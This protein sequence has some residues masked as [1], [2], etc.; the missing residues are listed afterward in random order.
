MQKE[1][2]SVQTAIV[3][4]NRWGRINDL[5]RLS[6]GKAGLSLGIKKF[7]GF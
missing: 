6:N 1:S 3:H 7:A 2:G 4:T 5:V